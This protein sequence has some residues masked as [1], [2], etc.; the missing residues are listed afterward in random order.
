MIELKKKEMNIKDYKEVDC[1][2]CK[3]FRTD[4]L[5]YP[6]GKCSIHNLDCG[7]GFCCDDYNQNYRLI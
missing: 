2:N 4:G 1:S 6:S 7:L 3:Y 5:S